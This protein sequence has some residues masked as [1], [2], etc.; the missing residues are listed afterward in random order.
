MSFD[1]STVVC[2]NASATQWGIAWAVFLQV[3]TLLLHKIQQLSTTTVARS[4]LWL[5]MMHASRWCHVATSV[6]VSCAHEVFR[7]G[8]GCPICRAG[9]NM[10]LRLY[11]CATILIFWTVLLICSTMDVAFCLC[12]VIFLLYYYILYWP[13]KLSISYMYVY[14]VCVFNFL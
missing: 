9:I 5:S 8:R 3:E 10:I 2:A 12:T 6:S 7:Q 14:I 11:Q 4:A 1:Q 13:C